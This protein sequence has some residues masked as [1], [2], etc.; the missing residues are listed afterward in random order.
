MPVLR[1]LRN[2]AGSGQSRPSQQPRVLQLP[3]LP[4]RRDAGLGLPPAAADA[5]RSGRSP[6]SPRAW[7]ATS[8]HSTRCTCD[9]AT[10][11]SPMASPRSS[12]SRGKRSR[13]WT[14]CSRAPIRWSSSPT[15]ATIRSSTEIRA[16]YPHHCFI[17]W[18]ILDHY[19][20]EF[21]QTPAHRQPEPRLPLAAGRR[22][23]EGI[24][25][26]DDQHVHRAHPALARQSRQA[27]G[28]PLP[29][30]RAARSRASRSS[31][32]VTRSTTASRSSAA[33]W[34]SS[35]RGRTRGIASSQLLNPAWMR[36]WPESFL[37]PEALATGALAARR[38]G[39]SAGVPSRR[40]DA[41]R[42][43]RRH[44]Q[45]RESP[46]GGALRRRDAAATTGAG[47]RRASWNA[48]GQRDRQS[49]DHED[50]RE[51]PDRPQRPAGRGDVRRSPSGRACSSGRS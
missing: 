47:A 28:V 10:S 32:A 18:H 11:R 15:S 48:G 49:R 22:R 20:A 44:G 38:E 36:E 24:H 46:G 29:V 27:R 6:S 2:A 40:A 37:T 19:G 51:L 25:R 5:G 9:A 33:R 30:E 39:V 12:A 1:R 34:S 16:A 50:G 31:A 3:V 23:V 8:A 17:D 7:P 35:T 13:R 43:V 26:H 45:L 21:A 41:A 42:A 14:R 4:R